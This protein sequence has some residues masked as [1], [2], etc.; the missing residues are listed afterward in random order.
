MSGLLSS[1]V[2][3]LLLS[4]ENY[5]EDK[6]A[7]RKQCPKCHSCHRPTLLCKLGSNLVLFSLAL[8]CN[9]SC[10][11]NVISEFSEG[12]SLICIS[13]FLYWIRSM[14]RARV[15]AGDRW[16]C[17]FM[18]RIL[19]WLWGLACNQQPAFFFQ[20]SSENSFTVGGAGSADGSSV[21]QEHVGTP[22]E[23]TLAQCNA[24][25]PK[26][27]ARLTLS[28]ARLK[29]RLLLPQ[30]AGPVPSVTGWCNRTCAQWEPPQEPT[31]K[32]TSSHLFNSVL[33]PFKSEARRP[34]GVDCHR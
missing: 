3:F 34:F 7:W 29:E 16:D 9:E 11:S 22:G 10:F 20:L 14:C 17:L 33:M 18:P 13:N 5:T 30:E 31:C 19:G 12:V 32:G 25:L 8:Y 4:M 1:H 21:C 6:E 24:L 26:Q 23:I 2:L 28:P 27:T 15:D